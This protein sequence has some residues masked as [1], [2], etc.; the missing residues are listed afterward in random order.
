[1]STTP[2][3]VSLGSTAIPSQRKRSVGTCPMVMNA[4]L[5]AV[6]MAGEHQP[7]SDAE[8]QMKNL[9]IYFIKCNQ[10]AE[11]YSDTTLSPVKSKH[12]II[13]LKKKSGRDV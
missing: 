13:A 8:L 6:P 2:Q 3:L 5:L 1:M 10:A 9:K 4:L 12:C 7:T 11:C